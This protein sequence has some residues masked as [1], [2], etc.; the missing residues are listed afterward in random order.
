MTRSHRF[1]R[2]ELHVDTR[3]LVNAD[4]RKLRLGARAVSLLCA[5]I[6]RRGEAVGKDALLHAVWPD[7][8]VEENNLPVQVA[9]LRKLLGR[10]AIGTVPGR[11]YRLALPVSGPQAAAAQPES[12]AVAQRRA[13]LPPS[14]MGALLGRDSDLAELRAM[15]SEHKVVTVTGS[16]GVGKTTLAL[17]AAHACGAALRDGV[18]WVDLTP[19]ASAA[20]VPRLVAQALRIEATDDDAMLAALAGALRRR[21]LLL[22]LDNAEHVLAGV[23]PLVRALAASST[24]L[25]LL[26]TSQVP[27]KVDGE[28]VFRLEP[29]SV[30]HADAAPEQALGHGAVALFVDQAQAVERRFA[31]TP[32]NTPR[33]IDICRRL[34]GLP[35][36]IKLAA[37]R[38]HLFGV[39]GLAARLSHR[40]E[41]LRGAAQDVPERRR[42]LSAALAWS[43]SLLSAPA[44]ALLRRL[45]VFA[46]GFTL[47]LAATV[48]ADAQLDRWGVEDALEELV[49][50]SLVAIDAREPPRY[51]LLESVR[52][53]ALQ[54]LAEAGEEHEVR[55]R[56]AQAV[57]ALFAAF[58]EA[59]FTPELI[60]IE[61]ST[62][63]TAEI[64]NLRAALN[65]C[66]AHDGALGVAILSVVA[67]FFESMGLRRE[68]RMWH[69]QFAPFVSKDGVP[70]LTLACFRMRRSLVVLQA[71]DRAAVELAASAADTFRS[72]GETVRLYFTLCYAAISSY[73][74]LSVE[75]AR[76]VLDELTAIEMPTWAPRLRSH[77]ALAAGVVLQAEGRFD[78]ALRTM[79]KANA[80]TREAGEDPGYGPANLAFLY[81][82]AGDME[83]AISMAREALAGSKRGYEVAEAIALSTLALALLFSGRHGQARQ[84]IADFFAVCED[85][86]IWER[87]H[88]AADVFALFA[89]GEGRYRTAA[90]LLGFSDHAYASIGNR[91]LSFAR[92]HE[93]AK[94]AVERQLDT[95][96]IDACRA[97]G[98]G[99]GIPEVLALTLQTPD[100]DSTSPHAE[101]PLRGSAERQE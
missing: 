17:A 55:R 78:E 36:G 87:V 68:E 95:A 41:L 10:H 6:E 45:G 34:D 42:S 54:L 100:S 2:Y 22:V 57:Q 98:A 75:A 18:V 66:L 11:G 58:E 46:G 27:L 70:A 37:A 4:G 74:F 88:I 40:L 14:T 91:S 53:Y 62:A 13:S 32:R 92:A 82:Q 64:D 49:D 30:P 15:L 80:L 86:S 96:T 28:R 101:Q 44:Q 1:D 83:G 29:L 25:R 81:L 31:L 90:Q 69:D 56:H 79:K 52:E 19:I 99:L 47:E 67:I 5:L 85:K 71:R 61:Y 24:A 60:E 89:A 50:H 38:V 21:E 63:H 26:V 33:V 23:A 3:E 51:H 59:Y 76:K 73:N 7:A 9:A 16:A 84:P 43:H 93:Q 94:T 48:G 35:L 97:A 65:W 20:L 8:P 39:E 77:G 72:L 12:S